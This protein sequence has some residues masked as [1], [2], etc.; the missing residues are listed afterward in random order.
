MNSWTE[1]LFSQYAAR[2]IGINHAA[3]K[4]LMVIITQV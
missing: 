4:G 2:G 1:S 3:Y